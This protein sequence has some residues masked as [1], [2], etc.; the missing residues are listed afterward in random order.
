MR[1]SVDGLDTDRVGTLRQAEGR[2]AL[3][4]EP[5]GDVSDA[6]LLFDLHVSRVGNGKVH[7]CDAGDIVAVQEE[8]HSYLIN[9]Y[10]RYRA[11]C[12]YY[13]CRHLPLEKG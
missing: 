1:V 13:R 2:P 3:G 9:P 11:R 10:G 5:V 6:V 12:G 8:R 7:G 4:I